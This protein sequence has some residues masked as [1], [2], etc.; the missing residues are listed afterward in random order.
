MRLD[1]KVI[2]APLVTYDK[3]YER[4]RERVFT[5]LFIGYTHTRNKNLNL[6]AAEENDITACIVEG[7]AV[8]RNDPNSPPWVDNYSVHFQRPH[9]PQGATGKRRRKLDV[10]FEGNR[11]EQNNTLC[12]E[13]KRLYPA[14]TP[15]GYFGIQGMQRF[16][17]EVYPTNSE[18]EAV[19]LGYVQFHNIPHWLQWLKTHFNDYR[20]DLHVPANSDWEEF[21]MIS[22][23]PH[24]F[25][26][27]HIPYPDK[28]TVLFHVL[29]SFVP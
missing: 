19:M 15:G 1:N 16:L 25:R 5:L 22:Q 20:S 29:L 13:A 18:K 2:F 10:F 9:S 7:I 11:R 6:V 12:F 26:T 3:Y 8:Y 28:H 24:S 27:Q 17:S 23:L 21:P 14:Q 4:F